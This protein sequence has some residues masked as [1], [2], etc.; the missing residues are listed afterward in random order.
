MP[1]GSHAL[2]ALISFGLSLQLRDGRDP[3]KFEVVENNGEWIVR[4]DGVEIARFRDQ[5]EALADVGER[6][7]AANDADGS[8]SLA[9]RYEARA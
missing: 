1:R 7:R 8:Y 2:G 9:M 3:M 6:L 5:L 4:R